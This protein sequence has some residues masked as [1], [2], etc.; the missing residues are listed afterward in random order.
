MEIHNMVNS[1]GNRPIP[2]PLLTT[3]KI[4]RY[5]HTSMSQVKRWIQT[6]DLKAIKTTGGHFRVRKEDFRIFL[7]TMGMPI[8]EDFFKSMMKKKILIADDDKTLVD[9][10]K[11][12]IEDR[13]D[14]AEI[15]VAYDGYETLIKAGKINPD[16]LLLDIRMPKIDGLEVCR[17][18]RKD[19]LINED[20][21]ILA[22]SAHSE[23][24]TREQVIGNGADEYLIKP[25]PMGTLIS[26][27]KKY[28]L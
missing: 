1:Y 26:Q 3:G 8:V 7:E 22:M 19:N 13:F 17:R 15:E 20:I 5:C 12:I 24:Y 23:E 16:I 25:I 21:F 4:A 28:L 2:E 10:F 14:D 9:V 11:S 6:G 18:L 27:L